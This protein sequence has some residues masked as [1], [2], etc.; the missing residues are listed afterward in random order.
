MKYLS[1]ILIVCLCAC[2][3]PATQKTPDVYAPAPATRTTVPAFQSLL[4]SQQLDGSILIYDAQKDEFFSNDFDWAEVGRLPASTYKIPHSLI[5]LETG[6]VEDDSTLFEWDGE[7]RRLKMWEADLIFRQAFHKSCV[8]C[9]QEIARTVGRERMQHYVDTL[10][11]GNMVITDS[12]IDL[13]WL[14]GDSKISQFEQIDFLSRFAQGV[15][16]ISQRSEQI[17]KRL[18]VIEE[19]ETYVLRGKT[20]WAIREDVN[21][22]GGHNNGWFVGYIN[23]GSETYFFATNVSPQKAFDM[24]RFSIIRNQIT[25]KAFSQLGIIG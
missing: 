14:I 16:P 23:K 6:V 17:M 1:L 20:G 11:Y 13:F 21:V 24:K 5:A 10:Q 9:Y 4:D 7:P 3:K 8:P 22:P 18:M 15:L 19:T 25:M 12:T 2:S